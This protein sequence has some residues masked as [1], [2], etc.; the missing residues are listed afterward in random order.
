MYSGLVL[1][2]NVSLTT[3]KS[4]IYSGLTLGLTLGYD[5]L[6]TLYSVLYANDV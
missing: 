4:A 6:S 1:G 3:F 2:Y 5:S